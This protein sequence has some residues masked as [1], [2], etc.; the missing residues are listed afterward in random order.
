MLLNN[1]ACKPFEPSAT[2][3]S[4]FET[5]VLTRSHKIYWDVF[6][7]KAEV[8]QQYSFIL[9]STLWFEQEF[10]KLQPSIINI[11]Q[12]GKLIGWPWTIYNYLLGNKIWKICKPVLLIDFLFHSWVDILL[13]LYS[14]LYFCSPTNR[15]D[16][17]NKITLFDKTDKNRPSKM[18][19]LPLIRFCFS[20]PIFIA[21]AVY[22]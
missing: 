1:I 13:T 12:T 15:F 16:L 18:S 10:W 3:K 21:R 22:T 6:T 14:W 2:I 5:K 7:K 19:E 11:P 4:Y 9:S 20:I 8:E 17:T